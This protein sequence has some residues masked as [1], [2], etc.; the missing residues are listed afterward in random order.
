MDNPNWPQIPDHLYEV[1]K[2]GCSGSNTLLNLI[3]NQPDFDKI[4][5]YAKDSHDLKNQLL[6]N[7]H[8]QTHIKHFTDPKMLIKYSID[9]Q[10]VNSNIDYYN[11]NKIE[12]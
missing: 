7:K 3:N 2:I 8:G 6:I 5:Q 1:F 9:I 10:D 11:L 12:K 4:C